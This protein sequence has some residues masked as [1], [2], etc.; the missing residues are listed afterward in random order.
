MSE[1][2]LTLTLE[3]DRPGADAP[4]G[5]ANATGKQPLAFTGWLGLMAAVRAACEAGSDGPPADIDPKLERST[6]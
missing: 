5:R 1:H 6:R 2:Q 3:I 4:T